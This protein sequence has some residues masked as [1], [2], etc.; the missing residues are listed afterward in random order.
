PLTVIGFPSGLPAKIEDSGEVVNPRSAARDYFTAT[1]DTFA[2]NSGS[3]VFDENGTL[4]G[5]LVR[6]ARDYISTGTCIATNVVE[7]GKD[8]D[9]GEEVTYAARAIEALC[10]VADGA[11]ELCEGRRP[12][13]GLVR[14][15]DGCAAIPGATGSS[16]ALFGLLLAAGVL[17]RRRR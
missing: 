2:G 12:V 6:G 8:F 16:A 10:R 1:T 7:I 15:K 3:G 14:E 17:A 13:G 11:S 5:I 4:V 9:Q